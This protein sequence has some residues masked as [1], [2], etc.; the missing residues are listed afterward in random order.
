MCSFSIVPYAE[1]SSV[2]SSKSLTTIDSA[3]D[4]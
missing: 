2:G 4:Q 1:G 3:E